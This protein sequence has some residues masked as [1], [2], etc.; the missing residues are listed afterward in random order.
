MFKLIISNLRKELTFRL[1]SLTADRQRIAILWDFES[2][3]SKESYFC[4]YPLCTI[5]KNVSE[6]LGDQNSYFLL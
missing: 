6:I 4:K 3:I 2:W 1:I 5:L